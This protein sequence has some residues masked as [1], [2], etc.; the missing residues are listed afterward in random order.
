MLVS[1]NVQKA[2]V[3]KALCLPFLYLN[4]NKEDV[5]FQ[6]TN[7]CANEYCCLLYVKRLD[8]LLNNFQASPWAFSSDFFHVVTFSL[9][10]LDVR[11]SKGRL[12]P[13][14][15]LWS[16]SPA[17]SFKNLKKN[18]FLCYLSKVSFF[19]QCPYRISSKLFPSV[20]WSL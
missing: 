12:S 2:Y 4:G 1:V 9:P 16:T 15:N 7:R 20:K 8:V 19:V 6:G 17:K 18:F 5:C 3:F 13:P 11:N 10:V 14:F